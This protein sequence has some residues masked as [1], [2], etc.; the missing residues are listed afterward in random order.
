MHREKGVYCIRGRFNNEQCGEEIVI[1]PVTPALVELP[2]GE[3]QAPKAVTSPA[4][5]TQKEKE[6]HELTHWPFRSW[7]QA[8]VAGRGKDAPH[9][10]VDRS[11]DEVPTV[12]MDY[13]FL[14][15]AGRLDMLTALVVKDTS[16]G[17]VVSISVEEKG[18]AEYPVKVT[19]RAL[20]TWGYARIV[21]RTDGEPAITA[22]A[23]AI[24]ESRAIQS[25]DTVVKTGPRYSSESLGCRRKG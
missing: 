24:K 16:S 21:L 10:R 18:P 8:C 3:G 7:C 13:M 19:T 2:E 25:Q 9:K 15:E 6:E 11:S 17:A 23:R 20:D 14:P 12:D 22:L 1:C 5:P 4:Q